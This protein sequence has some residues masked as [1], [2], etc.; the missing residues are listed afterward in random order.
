MGLPEPSAGIVVLERGE[1]TPV[2]LL[3]GVGGDHTVWDL[4]IP[5]LAEEFR[6]IAPDLR[7][8][9]QSAVPEGSEFSFREFEQ[10]LRQL[11]GQR[12]LDSAHFVGLSAGAL[13]ALQFALHDPERVRSLVLFAAAARIDNHTRAVGQSWTETLESEGFEPYIRR[14][15]MDLFAP[16]WLEN[17]MEFVDRLRDSQ[18]GRDRRGSVGW[19]RAMMTFDLRAQVGRLRCP[20]LLVHGMEDRVVDVSH[21]RLLRQAIP[22]AEV[23]LLPNAGHMIPIEAPEAA[24][25]A[26]R[27]WI[28]RQEQPSVAPG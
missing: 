15:A 24:T 12:E 7:G 25:D 8:H 27:G 16:D 28:R 13:L 19:S 6:T 3:H 18:R 4:E 22:G 5:A 1:G 17:H 20:T 10:D 11:L 23:R 26:I 14:L 2:V 21:A 9:G